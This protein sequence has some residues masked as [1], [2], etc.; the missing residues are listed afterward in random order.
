M[1]VTLIF[2]LF[3]LEGHSTR[4]FTLKKKKKIM[5][6]KLDTPST[7]REYDTVGI[8][9]WFFHENSWFGQF[10]HALSKCAKSGV[11]TPKIKI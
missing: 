4:K 11:K 10:R 7:L 2:Y 1:P 5:D 8:A 3:Y 9:N 6:K